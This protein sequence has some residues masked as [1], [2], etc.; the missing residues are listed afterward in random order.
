VD[1][2]ITGRNAEALEAAAVKIRE[3]T[4]V[5][6]RAAPGDITTAEGRGAALA[7]CPATDILVNNAGRRP[8]IFGS[9]AM[10]CGRRR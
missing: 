4:G 10:R 9:S 3:A 8:G 7:L 2:V 1:L 5:S 6:V